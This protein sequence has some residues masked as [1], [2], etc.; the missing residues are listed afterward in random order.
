MLGEAEILAEEDAAHGHGILPQVPSGEQTLVANE[1]SPLLGKVTEDGAVTENDTLGEWENVS[2]WWRPSVCTC[3][4][5]VMGLLPNRS[6]L[7]RYT[8]C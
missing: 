1:G 5:L 4:S 6:Y 8:G 7:P 2:W 3:T